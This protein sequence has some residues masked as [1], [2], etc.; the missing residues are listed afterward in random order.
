MRIGLDCRSINWYKGTGIGTYSDN[1]FKHILSMDKDNFYNIFWSG[2]NPKMLK[3]DNSKISITS[4]RH[5]KFFFDYFIPAEL[6][7]N[8]IDIF[9]L[10]Q[11][12]IG[13]SENIHCK[14]IVTIHDLIP[15]I[16]P[17]TVGKSYLNKF[18]REMPYIINN[19]DAIITVSEWS[20][21][22]I[23]RF[24]SVDSSKVHV[25]PLATDVKY[26]PINKEYCYNYLKNKYNIEDDYI[27]YI[28]GFSP[29]KN[30]R[31]LVSAFSKIYNDLN[32]KYKLVIVGPLRDEGLNIKNAFANSNIADALVFTGF[33]DE[34]ELPIL[35][36]GATAF[37]YP[38]FYEGF[39][40]PPLESMS[41]GTPVIT[42]NLSSIPEVVQDAGFLIDPYSEIELMNALL[43]LLNDSDLQQKLSS[44]SLKRANEFSWQETA[45]KTLEV[46]KKVN[47][48]C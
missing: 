3:Q 25:T 41:C 12:G 44:L 21:R 16:M 29:R 14:K 45:R 17:E 15:Y 31:G 11:N 10:P 32:K 40:L 38:S 19:S 5:Q 4:R 35:Y 9:H 30:V 22:D 33:A 13:L 42:S 20:K 47:D 36:S 23:C 34:N 39:G 2:E 6:S 7:N 48:L 28:G 1:L 24:F 8:N 26:K 43:S 18:L 46:Y 37:V 27:L